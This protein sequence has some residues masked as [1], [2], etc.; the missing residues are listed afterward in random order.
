MEEP[1]SDN[2]ETFREEQS[3]SKSLKKGLVKTDK[4]KKTGGSGLSAD[5]KVIS[6]FD[7]TP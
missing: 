2:V 3:Q 4:V 5:K 7:K 1:V 6:K